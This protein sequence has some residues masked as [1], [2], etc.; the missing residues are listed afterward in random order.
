M[1][2]TPINNFFDN[3]ALA[4]IVGQVLDRDLLVLALTCKEFLALCVAA[5]GGHMRWVTGA[6]DSTNRLHWAINVMGGKPKSS[7]CEALAARNNRSGM[8]L[9]L[10]WHGVFPKANVLAAA[11]KEGHLELV[12]LLRDPEDPCPWDWRGC[13][14]AAQNGQLA[15]LQWLRAQD[16][17][18]P[19]D[20]QACTNAAANGHL[21]TLQW[22]RDNGCPST[23]IST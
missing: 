23:P 6:T 16:P 13:A 15:T 8:A 20:A 5:N 10:T 14:F 17:P 3:D 4:A 1:S 11:A 18:C 19:W 22:L 21:V 7:W 12:R 2:T 9:L